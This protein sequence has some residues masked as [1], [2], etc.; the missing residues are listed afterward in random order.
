MK[1]IQTLIDRRQ[2]IR[3]SLAQHIQ[4]NPQ[5]ELFIHQLKPSESIGTIQIP[6]MTNTAYLLNECSRSIAD[7]LQFLKYSD[8]TTGDEYI[9]VPLIS[10]KKQK[11]NPLPKYDPKF[12]D[13][14]NKGGKSLFSDLF[15]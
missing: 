11:S 10:T 7:E 2:N 9:E 1:R 13:L 3:V 14:F 12:F 8:A 15:K 5:E 4:K 6:V